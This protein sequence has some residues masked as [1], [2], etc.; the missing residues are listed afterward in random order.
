MFTRTWLKAKAECK[1]SL[2]KDRIEL[3]SLTNNSA[4]ETKIFENHDLSSLY[5]QIAT[6]VG[7]EMSLLERYRTRVNQRQPGIGTI[8][9]LTNNLYEWSSLRSSTA[10]DRDP[11]ECKSHK[12]ICYQAHGWGLLSFKEVIGLGPEKKMML[13]QTRRKM[14]CFWIP[15]WVPCY[16]EGCLW[17]L[18]SHS[19]EVFVLALPLFCWTRTS[20]SQFFPSSHALCA[21]APTQVLLPHVT[22]C[23]ST[24]PTNISS[25]R[26]TSLQICPTCT[27]KN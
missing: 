5:L 27:E 15:L 19:L 7:G 16:T 20:T 4:L 17:P 26:I 24:Q 18:D 1:K 23:S 21:R 13:I 6:S 9:A 12:S 8:S 14:S 25:L 11:E 10:V 2:A 22:S 3:A